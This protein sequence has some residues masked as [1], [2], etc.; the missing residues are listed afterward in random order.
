MGMDMTVCRVCAQKT[1]ESNVICA[2]C[3]FHIHEKRIANIDRLRSW[4][5][6][7][8]NDSW[9][10]EITL[11]YRLQKVLGCS[12]PVMA[13]LLGVKS[14]SGVGMDIDL[15]RSLDEHPELEHCRNK[16]SAR[17]RLKQ[18]QRGATPTGQTPTFAYEEDLQRY[19]H[20][21]WH[22]TPLSKDWE[23][24]NHVATPMGKYSTNEVGEIDL[25]ARGKAG[26]NWLV[27][28]LKRDQSSDETVG[29][30]LRYMGWVKL[31]RAGSDEE[32]HGLIIGATTDRELMYALSCVPNIRM[33]VYERKGENLEFTT[34]E[35]ATAITALSKLSPEDREALLKE[36][37]ELKHS[38]GPNE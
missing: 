27:V 36:Y 1:D 20:E 24:E 35:K 15:A 2:S 31:N 16:A 13:K 9:I 5:H 8:K 11:K 4:V 28:E 18:I 3:G 29:Q 23:L 34:P 33:L 25:L 21:N 32:V 12:L 30:L 7:L 22:K 6:R 38:R 14:K 19:L 37:S 10:D 26:N 17:E